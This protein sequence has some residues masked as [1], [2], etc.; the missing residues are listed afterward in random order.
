GA[1][2]VGVALAIS[3]VVLQ[4][5]LRNPMADP[6]I[7][8]ISAGAS[9]GATI[10]MVFGVGASLFGILYAIPILA[11][12]GALCTVFLVYS[13]SKH[14]DV[15]SMLTLLLIGVALTSF[16][17]A[18]VSLIRLLNSETAPMIVFWLLGSLSMTS[19]NY[20]YMVLPFVLVGLGIIL[21]FARDLNVMS[22]GEDSAQHLG[23]DIETLK[24]ILLV[25]VSLVT[26]AAVAISGIIGFIGLIIP[27]MMRLL[28]GSD[29]RI[30][31]PASALTGAIVLIVCDT[32]ART[33]MSPSELPVGVITAILGSPFF[34]YLLRAKKKSFYT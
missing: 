21:Y 16:F 19:W 23:I 30:L 25:C 1:G 8:G 26:A 20:V 12:I 5:L 11:F 9:F 32:L 31:I 24:K 33:I 34:I 22:L 13:I 14:G 2:L 10:A 4:A 18:I 27:H 6:Y 17:S 7:I 15:V 28:V 29:H 3:G